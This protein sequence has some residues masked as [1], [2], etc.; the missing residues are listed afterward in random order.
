[1]LLRYNIAECFKTAATSIVA[2]SSAMNSSSTNGRTKVSVRDGKHAGMVPP[3]GLGGRSPPPQIYRAPLSALQFLKK[4]KRCRHF[5]FQIPLLHCHLSE[6]QTVLNLLGDKHRKAAEENRHYLKTVRE[7][8]LLTATQKIAQRESGSV[9]RDA[10]F[11]IENLSYGSNCG[12]FLGILALVAKHDPIVAKKSNV[13]QRMRSIPT[14][15]FKM[16]YL[17]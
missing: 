9:F 13:D 8:L 4:F 10:D 16:Y 15:A 11:D 6:Q 5:H 3:G 14:T 17:M 2:F 12:N 1:M 7:V